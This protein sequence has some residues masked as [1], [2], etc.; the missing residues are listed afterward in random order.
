MAGA[1]RILEVPALRITRRR[2]SSQ[3]LQSWTEAA[4]R[5]RLASN[6]HPTAVPGAD[7]AKPEGGGR[8]RNQQVARAAK[9]QDRQRV[10][11]RTVYDDLF[12]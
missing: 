3:Y 9:S 6:L 10:R 8:R 12:R 11:R 7:T 4:R 5:R 1:T 2:R